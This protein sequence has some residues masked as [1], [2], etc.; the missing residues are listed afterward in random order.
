MSVA[1]VPAAAQLDP[2]H[3]EG[4][5]LLRREGS[6]RRRGGLEHWVFLIQLAELICPE[7][8]VLH[9][10]IEVFT[11]LSDSREGREQD[12]DNEGRVAHRSSVN[13]IDCVET[14]EDG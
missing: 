14:S 1:I 7:A 9:N 3:D 5:D 8:T 6:K 13:D 4:S 10:L 12:R 11:R 2:T